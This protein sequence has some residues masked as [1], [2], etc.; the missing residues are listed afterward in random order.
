MAPAPQQRADPPAKCNSC[1]GQLAF[2]NLQCPF[3]LVPITPQRQLSDAEARQA[4]QFAQ[5]VETRL[6]KSRHLHDRFVLLGFVLFVVGTAGS[7][8]LL[9]QYLESFLKIFFFTAFFGAALFVG[10]GFVVNWAEERSLNQAYLTQIKQDIDYFLEN[11]RIY[12]YEFDQLATEALP[13]EAL[14]QRFLFLSPLHKKT[15]AP[16]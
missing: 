7:Y 14:L 6:T 3:C 4:R 12:R 2:H 10:F 1:G 15:T 8:L 9:E 16:H 11:C 13:K 5:V